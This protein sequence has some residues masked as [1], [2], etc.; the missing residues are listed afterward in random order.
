MFYLVIGIIIALLIIFS[1]SKF[2]SMPYLR[3]KKSV[4]ILFILF[5]IILSFLLFRSNP[6]LISGIPALFLFMFRWRPLFFGLYNFFSKKK[7]FK[8]SDNKM[9][10]EEALSVLGLKEGASNKEIID[11]YHKMLKKNHP[12][13]GGSDWISS[14]INKAKETLLS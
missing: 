4:N 13:I 2:F 5:L 8:Y 3:F 10:R 11:S 1:L 7:K 12:D 14:K 9:T 6:S